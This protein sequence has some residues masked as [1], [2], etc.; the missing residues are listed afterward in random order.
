V[1]WEGRDPSGLATDIKGRWFETDGI[2][3]TPELTLN[4]AQDDF[5]Q[6]NQSSPQVAVAVGG[7]AVV[8]WSSDPDSY[9]ARVFAAPP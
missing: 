4:E 3:I 8:T 9:V 7:F 6:R 1:V 5:D 2:P